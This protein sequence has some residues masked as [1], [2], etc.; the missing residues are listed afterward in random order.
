MAAE[1]CPRPLALEELRQIVCGEGLID[2]LESFDDLHVDGM[3]DARDQPRPAKSRHPVCCIAIHSS[4]RL[5][6][7]G[8][9]S[10]KT[11][12]ANHFDPKD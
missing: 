3:Q 5:G 8:P 4:S 6:V 7:I 10:R 1:R 9:Q 12:R 2:P 11:P